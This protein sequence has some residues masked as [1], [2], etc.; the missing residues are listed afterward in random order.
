MHTPTPWKISQIGVGFEV[1]S[2]DGACLA[3]AQMI[4]PED[5]RAGSITRKANAVFIVEAVNAHAKLVSE[6]EMLLKVMRGINDLANLVGQQPEF[7]FKV[8]RMAQ[9]AILAVEKEL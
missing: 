8:Q 6:R 1:E 7:S 4:S 5:V 9:A 3:Q 2:A